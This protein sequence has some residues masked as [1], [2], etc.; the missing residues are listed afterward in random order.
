[1]TV[2]EVLALFGAVSAVLV[3]VTGFGITLVR[4]QT[5]TETKVEGLDHRLTTHMHEE[6]RQRSE[7]IA[8]AAAG[9]VRV[10]AAVSA[11]AE[12]VDRVVSEN[13]MAEHRAS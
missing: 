11:L 6:E 13:R 9:L 3:P 10:E 12:R 8:N 1:M 4:G 7:D 5:R 2:A